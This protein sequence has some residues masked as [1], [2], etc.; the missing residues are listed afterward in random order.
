M[1]KYTN[2]TIDHLPIRYN[3]YRNKLTIPFT[4]VTLNIELEKI[5]V[6]YIFNIFRKSFLF[7]YS[8]LIMYLDLS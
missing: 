3:M 4:A 1:V 6:M 5:K 7:M 8:N 2:Q